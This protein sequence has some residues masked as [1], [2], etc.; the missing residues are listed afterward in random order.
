MKIETKAF[1]E[2]EI[3]EKQLLY[4]KDGVLGFEDIHDYVLIDS[5]DGG[6][7]YWLQAKHIPEIAFVVIDPKIVVNDYQL[8]ADEKELKELDIT[9]PD[10]I[11]LFSIV[12]I[13]DDPNNITVNLLGP[14]V[15]NK[16]THQGRQIISTTDKYSVR[17]PL[18]N[19]K[20]E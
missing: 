1:G 5:I 11:L 16:K 18:L 8:E 12:T 19:G 6:P 17:H 3:S 2:I 13:N 15:I 7:L 10:D 14:I 9:N 20:G 4:F